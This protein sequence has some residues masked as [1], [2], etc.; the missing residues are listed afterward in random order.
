MSHMQSKIQPKLL[1]KACKSLLES[2]LQEK[3]IVQ[4]LKAKK[5]E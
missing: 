2:I 3:K 1:R 4:Q 5:C